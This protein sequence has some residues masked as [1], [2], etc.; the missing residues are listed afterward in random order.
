MPMDEPFVVPNIKTP[1]MGQH[2]QPMCSL[3]RR[4]VVIALDVV[5]RVDVLA[6]IEKV[7]A[8][9]GHVHC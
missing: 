1:D 8:V 5:R 3:Y 7:D 9:E 2:I 4:V 6:M